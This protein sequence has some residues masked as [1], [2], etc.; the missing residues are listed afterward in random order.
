MFWLIVAF[1]AGV[2]VSQVFEALEPAVQAKAT[3]EEQSI[4]G[5]I[6]KLIH[7]AWSFVFG[8]KKKTAVAPATPV[9]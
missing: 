2:I 8:G 1:V 5:S 9:K 7:G 4:Y 6:I 3:A